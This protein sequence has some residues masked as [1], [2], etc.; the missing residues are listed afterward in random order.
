MKC[1]KIVWETRI[2]AAKEGA[3]IFLGFVPTKLAD[4]GILKAACHHTRPSSSMKLIN[5]YDSRIY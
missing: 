4:M 2:M 1:S 5:S 3:F